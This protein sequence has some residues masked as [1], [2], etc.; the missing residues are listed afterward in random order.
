MSNVPRY[1]LSCNTLHVTVVYS[2]RAA[3]VAAH[4]RDKM[5]YYISMTRE[6]YGN[7]AS[8][9]VDLMGAHSMDGVAEFATRAEAEAEIE[10][11]DSVVYYTK[12]NET[13]RP[14]LRIK[15]P[16]QLTR[17]ERLQADGRAWATV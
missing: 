14:S 9:V 13:G 5:T 6:F 11:F 7:G 17:R 15:T 3:M 16:S 1:V 4:G 2:Y 10:R 12:H 8:T